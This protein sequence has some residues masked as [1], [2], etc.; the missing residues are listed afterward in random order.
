MRLT[1]LACT[2]IV[3]AACTPG[4]GTTDSTDTTGSQ[5]TGS[6]TTSATDP[7]D[8]TTTAAPTTSSGSTTGTDTTTSTDSTTSITSTTSTDATTTTGTTTEPGETG[9][10]GAPD[11]AC[12][13]DADCALH[14]DCCTCEGV[15]FDL[16]FPSC[17]ERCKQSQCSA[18][19]IDEAVC[20]LGVCETERLH[21]NQIVACDQAPPACPPDHLPETTDTCY[22][23][24]CVP[25]AKCDVVTDCA[26]C[27][28][29]MM[30]VQQVSFGIDS[31]TCEPIPPGCGGVVDCACVGELVCTGMNN[32][33]FSQGAVVSC[34]CLNC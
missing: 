14:S 28:A 23:G 17:D 33:C 8:T 5:T 25:A 4:T 24:K 2:L 22:T 6:Q 19:G 16:D 1:Y 27:P 31:I 32:A 3:L 11:T 26:Q 30:C 7:G 29:D 10:T 13:V 9:T 18:L 15:P 34:E 21:C 20:R 12:I